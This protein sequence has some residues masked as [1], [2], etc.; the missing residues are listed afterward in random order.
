VALSVSSLINGSAGGDR[1]EL[2]DAVVADAGIPVVEVDGGVA[3]VGDQADLVAEREPVGGGR[4]GEP[5]VLV[6]G[7]LVGRGGLIADK[8]RAR[9]EGERLQAGIDA[10][11]RT[12][13]SA[14]FRSGGTG[15]SNPASS[16]GESVAN[17]TGLKRI[18]RRRFIGIP[19]DLCAA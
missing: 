6:G 16:S 14:A 3:M 17:P 11:R 1:P 9:I 19:F 5:A 8:R 2:L 15:S 7:A 13:S 12:R 10:G 18:C 4:D